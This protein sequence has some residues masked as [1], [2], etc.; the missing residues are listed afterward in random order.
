MA[1][2]EPPADVAARVG[3]LTDLELLHLVGGDGPALKGNL[4]MAKRYNATPIVAGRLPARGIAG[5]AFTDGPRGV[6]MGRSTAFPVPMARGAA[7]DPGLEE[8]IGDAIGV[9]ARA[10]GADFFGGVCINLLRH[11]AWGRAQ[12]T[13]GEDS[14]LLGEMGAALVRG[15]QRHVM[16]CIKHYACNSMENSRFWVDVRIDEADLRDLYLPHFRRCVDEGAASVMSAYNKVNGDWCGGHRHL[17]TEVLKDDWGFDGFVISDFTFGVRGSAQACL[18]AGLDVEMPFAWRVKRLGRAV[19]A[20]RL[21]RARLRDAAARLLHQQDRQARRGEPARYVSEA[22][23]SPEHRA[24]AHR[25]A[26]DGT[27][28][29]QNDGLLPFDPAKVRS[30]AVVGKLAA[31]ANTGDLGSSRVRAPE[32]VTLLDGLRVAAERHGITV[33]HHDGDDE[34]AC[35]E[36]A[37]RCD[38]V[39]LAVGNTFRDE[40]EWVGKDGGDRTRLTLRP[41]DEALVWRVARVNACTAVV[42]YGGSAFVT[43]AWRTDVGAILMAWYPGME[44]GRALADVLVGDEVPGGR[45]PCTWPADERDL[46]R[47]KRFARRIVYGPLHG[48]RKFEADGA[49]PAFP[50]GFGLSYTTIEWGEPEVAGGEARVTLSNTGDRPGV[51]VVQLYRSEALGTEPRAL[52]TLRGF[53]KVRLAPGETVTAAVPLPD[54]G[55]SGALWLGA[56]SDPADLVALDA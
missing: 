43:E 6:V 46:P 11:P 20:G 30:V 39:V 27:V 53:T 45:L 22:V 26:V 33:E 48:Y 31:I 17:L 10:Q 1:T 23:A 25:A 8:Q 24:L 37:A 12:E 16:A 32:V 56:S 19:R 4:E 34:D 36:L 35:A 29:L 41:V 55:R 18:E 14:H 47:F 52:R 3:E 5:I 49:H 42:L 54:D 28:L 21:D 50:F 13:Y 2:W 51:E 44:G 40:G 9:E 7:F 38:A 15:T